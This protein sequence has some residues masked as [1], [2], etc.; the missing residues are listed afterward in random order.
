LHRRY[1]R[2]HI[3]NA[4]RNIF[5]YDKQEEKFLKAIIGRMN[6]IRQDISTRPFLVSVPDQ[7]ESSSGLPFKK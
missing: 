3:I 4:E 5:Y 7:K 2:F 1:A 6:H